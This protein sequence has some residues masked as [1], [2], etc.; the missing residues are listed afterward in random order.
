MS[1]TTRMIVEVVTFV[2][3]ASFVIGWACARAKA[4]YERI[5]QWHQYEECLAK[6]AANPGSY[7]CVPPK[8]GMNSHE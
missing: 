7:L 3:V 1:R 5:Q 4:R 2:A 6:D 8:F